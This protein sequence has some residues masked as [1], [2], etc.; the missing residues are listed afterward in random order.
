[1]LAMP[2][3]KIESELSKKLY[4][5]NKPQFTKQGTR[6]FLEISELTTVPLGI[7][8]HYEPP[9]FEEIKAEMAKLDKF[10]IVELTYNGKHYHGL[11]S[12]ASCDTASI[13]TGI[14]IAY[15]RAF[16]E[17]CVVV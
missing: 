7:R 15:N 12:K 4:N 8:G 16:K 6:V 14:S 1:M 11:S 3:L 17:M 9:S 13:I 5:L 10:T 2:L